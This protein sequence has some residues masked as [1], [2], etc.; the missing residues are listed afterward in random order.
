MLT[1]GKVRMFVFW[2]SYGL[3]NETFLDDVTASS[4]QEAVNYIRSKYP[5]AQVF[6]VA[7]VVNNWK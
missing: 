7:K 5:E 6:E 3:N 4:A 2:V 1:E